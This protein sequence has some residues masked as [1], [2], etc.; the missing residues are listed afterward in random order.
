MITPR[1][2]SA[3]HFLLRFDIVTNHRLLEPASEAR[4]H[5][6]GHVSLPFVLR[7]DV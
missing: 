2:D 1:F 7:H 3:L 6:A 4:H 5:F